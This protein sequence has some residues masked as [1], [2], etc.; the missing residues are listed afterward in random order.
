MVDV[1]NGEIIE[2]VNDGIEE[3]QKQI[4]IDHGYELVHHELV[5]YVKKKQD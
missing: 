5:L 1:D 3:L 4:A 2:F